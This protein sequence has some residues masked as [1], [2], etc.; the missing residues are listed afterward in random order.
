MAVEI[1]RQPSVEERNEFVAQVGAPNHPLKVIAPAVVIRAI[2]APPGKGPLQ[3]PKD[4]LMPDV[5]PQCDV[6]LAAVA[7]EVTLSDQEPDEESDLELRWHGHPRCFTVMLHGK[8]WSCR[9][10]T[11]RP[12][13][14]Y[15]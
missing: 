15:H 8:P 5:H 11:S 3:P 9:T 14:G 10:A 6:G 13:A 2:E 7:T 1:R 4:R 12:S